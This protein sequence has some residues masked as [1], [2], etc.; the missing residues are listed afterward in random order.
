L[1]TRHIELGID[2]NR[3]EIDLSDVNAG[4]SWTERQL[5]VE[6]PPNHRLRAN[7]R[8]SERVRTANEA[9]FRCF[10]PWERRRRAALP[11]PLTL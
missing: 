11:T 2:G 10:D 3:F 9:S 1:R 5:E 6:V 4:S 7:R 8:S